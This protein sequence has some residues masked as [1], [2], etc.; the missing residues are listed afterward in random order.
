MSRWLENQTDHALACVLYGDCVY[1]VVQ[2][3]AQSLETKWKAKT[4]GWDGLIDKAVKTG[5]MG[6][7]PPLVDRKWLSH[8]LFKGVRAW[9]TE[10]TAEER[11]LLKLAVS[12]SAFHR[13]YDKGVKFDRS[14]DIPTGEGERDDRTLAALRKYAE[15]FKRQIALPM[16][17]EF[18]Q[19]ADEYGRKI[20]P[21]C[22]ERY[23]EACSKT[24]AVNIF[25]G[26]VYRGMAAKTLDVDP[27]MYRVLPRFLE[28]ISA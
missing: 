20:Q 8:V 11:K 13:L 7:G 16:W 3:G 4:R 12:T 1:D 2:E 15:L 19:V 26:D 22:A 14:R 5:F 25:K 6:W 24:E 9:P 23:G 18:D 28:W 10:L 27:P 17:K 21:L